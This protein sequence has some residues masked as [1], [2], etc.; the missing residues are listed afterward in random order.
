MLVVTTAAART[1][2]TTLE[3]VKSDLRIEGSAEDAYLRGQ[4]AVATDLI[5]RHL[6][7]VPAGRSRTLGRETL[8]ETLRPDRSR[9]LLL[10][11][12][13]PIV[14]IASVVEADETVDAAE[15]EIEDAAAGMVRRLDADGDPALW[16]TGRIVVTYTAGWLMPGDASADLPAAIEAAAIELVGS[17][18]SAR[19][20][21]PLV[22]SESVPGLGDTSYWI[23]SPM[24]AGELPPSVATKLAPYRRIAL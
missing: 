11:S 9:E 13:T 20:R 7:V 17:F 21:D 15:Y 22:R 5:T 4:I 8:V 19:G 3:R 23:Q 12:R 18:R 16:A 2:L 10:L 24:E 6:G 14:S 1:D